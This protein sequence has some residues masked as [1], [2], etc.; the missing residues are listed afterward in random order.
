MT[1]NESKC[2]SE[3][4]WR[5]YICMNRVEECKGVDSYYL[6]PKDGEP[7]AGLLPGQYVY[8]KGCFPSTG[9]FGPTSFP[10]S[11]APDAGL[12]RL[13]VK[14]VGAGNVVEEAS[15]EARLHRLLKVGEEIELSEPKGEF[16][17]DFKEEHP[18]VI[19]A[20]GI[21]IAGVVPILSALSTENPLRQ[22]H[23]LYTTQNGE[24][25]PL[26]AEVDSI[27]KG[28]PHGA[29]AVF[30]TSPAENEQIGRDYDAQGRISAERIR[31]FCQD[32]DADFWLTGPEEFMSMVKMALL[33][34]GVIAPRIHCETFT[35]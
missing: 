23:L 26:K 13:T 5:T 30:F 31:F 18:V 29:K 35:H 25:Y 8:V 28:L 21:N 2:T 16:T 12:L 33:E 17:F 20:A 3:L 27:M 1:T 19:I 32:P 14:Y 9:E 34:I 15:T 11:S 7:M 10:V 6:M 24:H 4:K 22:L